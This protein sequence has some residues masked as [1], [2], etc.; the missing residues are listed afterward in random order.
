MQGRYYEGIHKRTTPAYK[1][2]ATQCRDC[3]YWRSLSSSTNGSKACH[4][5]AELQVR[6]VMD[7]ND[8]CLSKRKRKGGA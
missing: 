4:Y 1:H 5:M 8:K 7:E 2:D 3:R 6:R